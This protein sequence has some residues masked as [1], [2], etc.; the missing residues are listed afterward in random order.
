MWAGSVLPFVTWLLSWLTGLFPF[1]VIEIAF[2]AW[3]IW[4]LAN[5]GS[6]VVALA[7]HR[8]HRR[9]A[10]LSGLLIAAQDLG[11]CLL[12]FYAA[13]GFGYARPD[14]ETRLDWPEGEPSTELLAQLTRDAVDDT[15]LRYRDL[16][17]TD[18]AGE[19]TRIDDPAALND[20]LEEGWRIACD[21]LG[22][23]GPIA[24][25]HGPHKRL[26]ISPLLRRAGLS[27]FYS[28][29]TGEAN[30]N[31]SVPAASRPQVIAHEKAHQRAI[32]PENEANFFGWL[33]AARAPDPVAR[34]SASVFAQRQLLRTLLER[35]RELGE[36]LLAA[37]LPG[38]QRDVDDLHEYWSVARGRTA[39]IS[40]AVND[41]Y[42]RTNRV[43][44]GVAAYGRSVFLLLRYAQTRGGTLEERPTLPGPSR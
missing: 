25:K 27:G 7:G 30:V 33:V 13:W 34:Y 18:D 21:E 42:L 3:A 11:I 35:D 39:R 29:F 9:N 17:A 43:E 10:V 5:V 37:R 1:S 20:A 41:A 24:W 2:A 23:S 12:I 8:R 36:D 31:R 22:L 28:P 38:V 32:N 15:N 26:I 19:P 4:R 44:G 6:A 40:R 14:L 16:H